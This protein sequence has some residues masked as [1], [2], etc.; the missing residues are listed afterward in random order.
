MLRV[1]ATA[2]VCVVAACETTGRE[3]P[4]VEI[5]VVTAESVPA[6]V[7]SALR[8]LAVEVSG[9]TTASFVVSGAP[10]S[11]GWRVRYRVP[12]GGSLTFT[13]TGRDRAGIGLVR[14]ASSVVV[15]SG[16]GGLLTVTLSELLARPADLGGLDVDLASPTD[17][18]GAD[19]QAK[20]IPDL[21]AAPDL[22]AAPSDLA[23]APS[24]LTTTTTDLTAPG[25][26]LAAPAG[27]AVQPKTT[28]VLLGGNEL[29]VAP[30]DVDWSIQGDPATA[31]ISASGLFRATAAGTYTVVATSMQG[32]GSDTAMV[33]V[34]AGTLDRIAGPLGGAGYLDGL[35]TAARFFQ[36][37]DL[38]DD[39]AGT[40]YVV[41]AGDAIIRKV[42]IATGEVSTLAG[43]VGRAGFADGVG[44]AAQFYNPRGIACD[45]ASTLYVADQGNHVVRK[46]DVATRTV[47]TLVGQPG[48]FGE[49]A[50]VGGAARLSNPNGL[51][52]ADTGTTKYLYVSELSR[53][54]RRVD[55]TTNNCELWA[56]T[57]AGGSIDGAV[58]TATFTQ[59][60]RMIWDGP[61]PG[62][63]YLADGFGSR[64]RAF[65]LANDTVSTLAGSGTSGAVDAIGTAASFRNPTGLALVD[66]GTTHALY[67]S[68]ENNYTIRRIELTAGPSFAGVTTVAGV[69]QS[70]GFVD[71]VG[72][73][74][75]LY[76]PA[77]ILAIGNLLYFTDSNNHTVRSLARNTNTVSTV[78]GW[79]W[80]GNAADGTGKDARFGL[81][82]DVVV[83][84]NLAYLADSSA[85]RV[86]DLTSGAVTTLAGSL[87]QTAVTDGTGPNARFYRIEAMTMGVDGSLFVTD[88]R[89]LRKVELATAQVTTIAGNAVE[90]VSMTRDGI[91]TAARL[92]Y[93]GAIRRQGSTLYLIDGAS[94]RTVDLA[95]MQVTTIIGDA[96]IYEYADGVGTAARLSSPSSVAVDGAGRLYIGDANTIRAVDLAT[97]RVTTLAGYQGLAA[98]REGIGAAARFT[99]VRCL[100]W[101]G[102]TSTLIACEP[103]VGGFVR[104]RPSTGAV[105][106]LLGRPGI[107]GV[108]LGPLPGSINNSLAVTVVGNAL[109]AGDYAEGALIHV[110]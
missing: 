19:D 50:G 13:A 36:P 46:I 24:D 18:G 106:L 28:S 37:V 20:P 100:D 91:G 88:R 73:A 17:L 97:R 107:H 63:L 39:G 10:T 49:I 15:E 74:A 85:I 12:A 59:P 104:V 86:V 76:A 78:A 82:S 61:W 109:F 40:L 6:E 62:V 60:S 81:I 34:R 87:T 47:S 103:E 77:G 1:A 102:A 43:K 72:A 42:V 84:G 16:G 68:D 26:D 52:I 45:G 32:L 4:A 58:A 101:D 79:A 35:G 27:F 38:C 22:A 51:A 11:G 69:A 70:A 105:T 3:A 31:S 25:A 67:V 80:Q 110:H 55:L 30:G 64:V 7:S 71:A 83:S 56:G 41:E 53:R 95:S 94:V 9:S 8:S 89:T 5:A 108:E 33:T 90:Y 65:D 96:L 75:R 14:G 93:P 54:V 66:D 57:G 98:H 99:D 23:P 48:S 29:F 21:S 44:S 2:L 92:L